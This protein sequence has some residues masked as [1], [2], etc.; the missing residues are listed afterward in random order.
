[1]FLFAKMTDATRNLNVTRFAIIIAMFLVFAISLV[2]GDS[3]AIAAASSE[4]AGDSKSFIS[5]YK[6]LAKLFSLNTK[7]VPLLSG[8]FSVILLAI[9]ALRYKRHVDHVISHGQIEPLGRFS[10]EVITETI[11]DFMHNLGRDLFHSDN[12]PYT[13]LMTALFFFILITNLTGLCPFL[14]PASGDFSANLGV[15]L[16]V[17]CLYNFWGVRTQGFLSYI[18]HFSG[19]KVPIPIIGLLLPVLLFVIEIISHGF[20]PVSLSLRLM[21]NI[22]GD[23]MLVGV[24]TGMGLWIVPSILLFFGVL[25]SLV[26]AFVFSLLSGIYVALA[27]SSDH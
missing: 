26:Q 10:L 4:A 3:L 1:M 15:A 21:G 13:H 20:R 5:F 23:H 8:L 16:V 7:F 12:S 22:F 24:F 2:L 14:P 19:P 25:V 6:L 17:F 9:I 18:K 11:C 27:V